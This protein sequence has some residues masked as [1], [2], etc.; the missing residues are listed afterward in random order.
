MDEFYSS[1][2]HALFVFNFSQ[3]QPN[4][5]GY[6]VDIEAYE[7]K[8]FIYWEDYAWRYKRFGTDDGGPW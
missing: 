5:V 2:A 3:I 1:D 6:P 8:G 4:P 7:G